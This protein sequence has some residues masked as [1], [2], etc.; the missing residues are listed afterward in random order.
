[1]RQNLLILMIFWLL[2]SSPA[3]AECRGGIAGLSNPMCTGGG[4]GGGPDLII[5]L[6]PDPFPG[7]FSAYQEAMGL[8]RSLSPT[9]ESYASMPSP[10]ND[11][12]LNVRMIE[13]YNAIYQDYAAARDAYEVILGQ[14]GYFSR[15]LPLI[16]QKID[17]AAHARDA[18]LDKAA[19][20]ESE[21]QTLRDKAARLRNAATDLTPTTLR[22]LNDHAN[23]DA[24]YSYLMVFSH[25]HD[26][27]QDRL[28][29]GEPRTQISGLPPDPAPAL[30]FASPA[31]ASASGVPWLTTGNDTPVLQLRPE[32]GMD[33]KLSAFKGL[34]A[35]Y[36]AILED[37]ERIRPDTDALRPQYEAKW[38]QLQ[39]IQREITAATVQ[40]LE[41]ERQNIDAIELHKTAMQTLDIT[42]QELAGRMVTSHA[43]ALAKERIKTGLKDILD[44]HDLLDD[45]PFSKEE[46][47]EQMARAGK[48][49]FIPLDRHPERW[50]AFM[51]TQKRTLTLV[52]RL[53][54]YT[55]E[56]ARLAVEGGPQE[57]QEHLEKIFA[58]VKWESVEYVKT[59]GMSA[60]PEEDRGVF[61]DALDT[62][63]GMR[64]E[65]D[66]VE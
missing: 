40:S 13:A 21:S 64:K 39:A 42:A 23:R 63:I 47:I 9:A 10:S 1:M 26:I 3:Q 19:R 51:E 22:L 14:H 66:G 58:F 57:M 34:A 53:Q 15:E 17:D 37:T 16:D 44:V 48:T 41:V 32:A 29:S 5:D 4:G 2:F 62:Y 46:A 31:A 8:L 30:P 18:L 56:A 20:L 6:P 50:E 54:G 25:A 49:F 33:D 59:A 52:E 12:E 35:N 61:I 55:T 43:E 7:H 11:T 27:T 24:I 45:I 65:K 36:K 28:W 38:E 60:L